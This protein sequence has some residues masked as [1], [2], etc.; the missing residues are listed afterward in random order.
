MPIFPDA[1][2]YMTAALGGI[3]HQLTV[4]GSIAAIRGGVSSRHIRVPALGLSAEPPLA[5]TSIYFKTACD[6]QS[7][8]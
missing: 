7:L 6:Q 8:A 2:A 5:T 4:G 1:V 3:E